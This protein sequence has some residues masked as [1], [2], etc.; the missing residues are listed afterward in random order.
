MGEAE[1]SNNEIQ[2]QAPAM[3]FVIPCANFATQ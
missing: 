3:Q 1:Y 2:K